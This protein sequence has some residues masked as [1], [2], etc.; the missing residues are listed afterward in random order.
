MARHGAFRRKLTQTADLYNPVLSTTSGQT[1]TSFS[2]PTY[3]GAPCLLFKLAPDLEVAAIVDQ[4]TTLYA[5]LLDYY[6]DSVPPIAYIINVGAKVIVSGVTYWVLTIQDHM[7][8][9]HH[10]ELTLREGTMAE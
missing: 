4:E 6:D 8:A 2:A 10:L 3:V 7:D 9:H 5:M 1:K